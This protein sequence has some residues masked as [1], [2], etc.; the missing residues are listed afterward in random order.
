MEE[1]AFE[2]QRFVAVMMG[3][4]KHSKF[5]D[6]MNSGLLSQGVFGERQ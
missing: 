3:V 1:L 4:L 6:L 2:Q 5:R